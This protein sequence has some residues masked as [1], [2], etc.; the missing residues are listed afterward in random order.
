MDIFEILK[1]AIERILEYEKDFREEEKIKKDLF[2]AGASHGIWVAL[3]TIRND[4]L[5]FEQ[6]EVLEKIGLSKEVEELF[7]INN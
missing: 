1:G 3:S 7:K 6:D 4:L 5:V 2:N